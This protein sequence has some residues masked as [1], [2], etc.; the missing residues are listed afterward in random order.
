MTRP[1]RRTRGWLAWARFALAALILALL[2]LAGAR[3]DEPAA[4][5]ESARASPDSTSPAAAPGAPIASPPRDVPLVLQPSA[6][7]IPPVPT[8]YVQKDLGW[9]V[10][11][12]PP[13]AHERVQPVIAEAEDVKAKLADELGQ[14]VL[15]PDTKVGGPRARVEVRVA[16]TADEMSALA[17]QELPPP[18]YASGVAY[19]P[20][21]LVILSLT[22]P[23]GAEPTDLGELFRHELAHVTLEDAVQAH[24]VPRWFNEGLAVYESGEG[25][26][27]RV[28]TLWDATLSR[29]RDPSCRSRPKLPRRPLRGEHRVRGVGGLR[30]LPPS[31]RRSHSLR[32]PHRANTRG[33]EL[34]PRT[35]RRLQ[36]RPPQAR[37]PLARGD[38]EAL[39]LPP[40]PHERLAPLGR[41]HRIERR[42]LGA[43][44]AAREGYARAMGGRG[45][46]ARRGARTTEPD[47]R[48]RLRCGPRRCARSQRS[49]TRGAGTR[50]TESWTVSAPGAPT[51]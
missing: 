9:M 6:I 7:R 15:E 13:G 4:T 40:G 37:V 1:L 12:Y 33:R 23:V 2:P 5:T 44:E 10:I 28:R 27:V 21:R 20:L 50:S 17:P 8:T 39:R 14:S 35:R 29:T 3:A 22:A 34:R 47:R 36:H 43:K 45:G 16:R 51:G 48:E 25:R 30:P 26:F 32:E 11:A 42:R 18:S 31:R 41:R 24:H 46:R 49:S 38:R 19:P